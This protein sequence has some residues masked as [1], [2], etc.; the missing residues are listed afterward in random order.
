MSQRHQGTTGEDARF[1]LR[2]LLKSSEL[3]LEL[4]LEWN[5][6]SP[7]NRYEDRIQNM[8]SEFRIRNSELP[9]SHQPLTTGHSGPRTPNSGPD[10]TSSSFDLPTDQ[11]ILTTMIGGFDE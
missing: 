11:E 5:R 8:K 7:R 3:Q 4:V 2:A 10:G 9:T 6:A 1:T